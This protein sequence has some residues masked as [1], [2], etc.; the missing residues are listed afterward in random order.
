VILCPN[1]VNVVENEK[2]R[3][4]VIIFTREYSTNCKDHLEQDMGKDAK[5]V[6]FWCAEMTMLVS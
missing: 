1:K 5:S 6:E 4:T 2:K 3:I